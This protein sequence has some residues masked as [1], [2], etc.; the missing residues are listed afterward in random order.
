MRSGFHNE[1]GFTLIEAIL[2]VVLLSFGLVG[3]LTLFRNV[4]DNSLSKN[5]QVIASALAGEKLESILLD[6]TAQGYGFILQ[7]NYPDEQMAAPNQTFTRS[8]TIQEVQAADLTTP[9]VGSGYKRI[10]VQVTWGVQNFQTITVSTVVSNYS[11]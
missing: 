8:V 5:N 11:G 9:Q 10:D 2:T 7:A 1:G 4:T 3:G 6:K